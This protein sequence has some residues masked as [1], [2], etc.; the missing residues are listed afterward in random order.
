M[1]PH[2]AHARVPRPR[3]QPV[4]FTPLPHTASSAAIPVK[5]NRIWQQQHVVDVHDG[6]KAQST[7]YF[8]SL[9]TIQMTEQTLGMTGEILRMSDK[10]IKIV[11]HISRITD[12]VTVTRHN[13][14]KKWLNH[15]SKKR[16]THYS[17]RQNIKNG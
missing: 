15:Y 7:F 4:G 6:L 12:K 5:F 14:I 8:F 17:A 16:L 9:N 13:E 1:P 10:I 11:E 3:A 2:P